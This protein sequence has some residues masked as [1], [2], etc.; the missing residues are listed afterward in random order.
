MKRVFV[1]GAA[2]AAAFS[3][4]MAVSA[5]QKPA[6]ADTQLPLKEFMGHV[7]DRNAAQLWR[8]TAYEIDEKGEHSGKPT[9]ELEWEEAESDALTL[10]QLTLLVE[11]SVFSS[12]ERWAVHLAGLRAAATASADA[13]ER[14]DYEALEKAGNDVNDQCVSCHLTFAPDLERQP[15]P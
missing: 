5:P 2:A 1:I 8:W 11:N 6:G 13:A 15:D 7:M 14:K 4:S 9:T 12:D 3:V 10:Q